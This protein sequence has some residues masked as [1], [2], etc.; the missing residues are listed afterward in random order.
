MRRIVISLGVSAFVFILIISVGST[1]VSS[2]SSHRVSKQRYVPQEVLIKYKSS[3]SPQAIEETESNIGAGTIKEFKHHGVK[4]LRLPDR[5]TVEKAIEELSKDP[6]VAYVEPNYI[7]YSKATRPNDPFLRYQWSLDNT[8]QT[9]NGVSGTTD[10]DIDAPEAWDATTGSVSLIVAV[11]DSGVDYNHPD[12]AANLIQGYDFV[13]NDND[14]IDAE[15]HGTHIAGI[16]GAVGNNGTGISGVCWNV[17]ILPLR[18]ADTSGAAY[19]SDVISAIDYAGQAGAKIINYSFGGYDYS[20]AL[21]D[22]ISNANASGILFVTASGNDANNNDINPHYPSSYNLPNILSVA[23]TDQNDNLRYLSNYGLNSVHIGAPGVNILSTVPAAIIAVWSDNFD[24]GNIGNW[25]SGGIDNTFGLSNTVSFNG[26][27]SLSDSPSGNYLNNTDS[28]IRSPVL[29]LLNYHGAVLEFKFTGESEDSYDYLYVETSTDGINWISRGDYITGNYSDAW[30]QAYVDLGSCDG[31]SSCFYRF[32]FF[33]DNVTT[34][35]GFYIDDVKVT[36]ASSSY[37]GTE[38][39]YLTGTS[40][41]TA[42]TSGVA[43]LVWSNNTSLSHLQVK[44]MILRGAVKKNSLAG[45]VATG[46][47][48]NAYYAITGITPPEPPPT[49]PPS[50]D[51]G[52]GGCFIATAAFGSPFAPYVMILRNFRDSVLLS[53]QAGKAF[54]EMYYHLSPPIADFIAQHDA[55]KMVIRGILLPLVGYC[56]LTLTYG[57]LGTLLLTTSF[58]VLGLFVRRLYI[59]KG[60]RLV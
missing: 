29:N 43:A 24:D 38:Y 40:M 20:Q 17:K 32:H 59:K 8:G 3:I 5:L 47:V 14:P 4:R 16:I 27:Y 41:S 31:K 1:L 57:P 10:A 25:T 51:G 39:D 7:H 42:L 34:Y 52:G 50:D 18:I 46:G 33:S 19:V 35:D 45:K 37:T 44:D 58:I 53:N 60:F 48:L 6:K 55:L 56:W 15:F 12:L 23:N 9:V 2:S 36:V 54:V 49:P 28:W 13:D 21:Y 11:L 22:T 30:Y 26:S